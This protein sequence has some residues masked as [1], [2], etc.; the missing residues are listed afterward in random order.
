MKIYETLVYRLQ[1]SSDL[2]EMFVANEAEFESTG[3]GILHQRI[4]SLFIES[5][6]REET[7]TRVSARPKLRMAHR[8]L[9]W[10]GSAR[11]EMEPLVRGC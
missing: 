5:G 1:V 2:V 9:Y 3:V 11:T 8:R 7:S 6:K 4:M 10:S